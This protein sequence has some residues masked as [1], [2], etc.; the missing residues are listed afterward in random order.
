M[1]VGASHG[2]NSPDALAMHSQAPASAPSLLDL[3]SQELDHWLLE[4]DQGG[5][6]MMDDAGNLLRRAGS[7]E[8][9]SDDGDQYLN[10]YFWGSFEDTSMEGMSGSDATTLEQLVA[11][12]ASLHDV[13]RHTKFSSRAASSPLLPKHYKA[14]TKV[15]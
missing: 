11:L 1:P 2:R 8:S 10:P 14:S 6:H 15:R 9:S 12:Q 3:D 5:E 7:W 4:N 13:S